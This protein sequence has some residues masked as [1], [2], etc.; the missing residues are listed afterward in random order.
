MKRF[1]IALLAVALLLGLAACAGE[2]GIHTASGPIA[3]G[4]Q[5]VASAERK[6]FIVDHFKAIA[7][8]MEGA[9]VG[10]VCYVNNIPCCVMRAIS[11]GGDENAKMDYPTFAKM[12]AERAVKVMLGL[13]NK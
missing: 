3:S 11:D 10:Q 12:A 13:L 9:A 5:F 2:L 7:C 1:L 4:D 8:E 6:A